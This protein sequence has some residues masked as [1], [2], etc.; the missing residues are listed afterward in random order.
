MTAAE[1]D[2]Y[3]INFGPH[4]P[5]THGVLRLSLEISGEEVIVC[6]PD[7]G[8]LHRGVEKIAENKK[9]V[10]IIPYVDRLDYL[11][12]SPQEHAYVTALERL[13]NIDPP[14]RAVFIRTIIDELTRISSHIMGIGSATYDLG[15]LSLFLYGFEEREKVMDIFEAITGARMHLACYVPGGVLADISDD[16]IERVY[17]FLDG[18]GFYLNAVEKMALNSRIF[19]KRTKN[20][21]VISAKMAKRH[22]ISGVNLRA[23]GIPYDIRK[24]IPYGA[25]ADLEFEPIILTG[26]DCYDRTKLRFLEI[27]QSVDLIKQCLKL[28]PSGATCN[29][30]H[31][32]LHSL[33]LPPHSI[34]YA[35]TE[36]PRGEF[37]VHLLLDKETTKPYRLHF[38]SPCFAH[39]QLLKKLLIGAQIPDITAILG[40]LDF[41]MGC[42]DR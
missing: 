20:I 22:G 32:S 41:I 28:M 17:S 10:S 33:T 30:L 27:Q 7:I 4:H 2:V 37:G 14:M 36:T 23:S 42:C 35:A 40:S 21:G 16:I 19:A 13:L 11:A 29:H 24:S 6:N 26:G 12:P 3:S 38:K 25:Y 39:V 8:Y 5:A 31:P 15:C 9:F 1:S 34:V 18:L